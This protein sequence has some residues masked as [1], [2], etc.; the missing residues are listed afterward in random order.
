MIDSFE[1]RIRILKWIFLALF[2]VFGLRLFDLQVIQHKEYYAEAKAQHEK[3][4]VLPARRGKILVRKNQLTEEVTPVATNNTLKMLFVD[5]LVLSYPEYNPNL[6]LSEQEKN[7]PRVAAEILAPIL[8]NAHCEKVEGCEI[9]TNAAEWNDTEKTAIRSYTEELEKKITEI[10]RRRVLLV[11]DVSEERAQKINNLHLPGIWTEEGSVL[12]DP[13][14]VIDIEGTA[15]QLAPLLNIEER[16]IR[17]WINRRPK[18]YVEITRKI[19]P[20]VSQKIMALKEDPNYRKILR[21]VGLKDEYWRYY[22]EKNLAAQVMGFVDSAGVGQYGIEGQ[23]DHLLKGREGYIFGATNTRGQRI[24]SKSLGISHAQDGADVVLTID[25]VIQDAVEKILEEDLIKYDADFGQ[26]VVLEP[27]TGKVLAMVHYPTFDPNEF[28]KAFL[29]YE[30]TPEQA[31]IDREDED[32]NQRIPTIIEEGRYYRYFNT[33]GPAVFRNKIIADTYEPGSVMKAVTMASALNSDEV[34]PQTTYDDDGPVEVDEFKIRNADNIYAGPT[35]MVEVLNRSLNTGIAFITKK[36][37][38]QVL[39]DYFKGFGFGQYTDIELE[40]EEDGKIKPWR[41]WAE[42]ELITYGFGQGLTATPLQMAVAFSALAN[43][44][45]LTKPLLIEEIRYPDGTVEKFV[46][47]RIR[48]VI[49]DKTYQTIK[50]MLLNA[51]DNGVARGARVWGY[52]VM[53]KTGTSQTY[54]RGKALEGAGTTITSFAGFGPIREPKFVVLV[55]YDHPK[56]SQW[57]SE[58]AAITFRRVAKF[59]FSYMGV[60]PDR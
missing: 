26:I 7:D 36:V 55:K 44:G 43:G 58:T 16:L 15:E 42:S 57:G 30:I 3:K 18:R 34:T 38:R 50:S 53:G 52:S 47:E 12:A 24:L 10:E 32:F 56:F 31:E 33:W 59:L 46:P 19:V 2:I 4:S 41:E 17:K 37:G 13:T 45:Y 9:K 25:R 23:Y 28:G 22:P 21:G 48:R 49:S 27:Q 35:T 5:P 14:R 39:Y 11:N 1:S 40:G 6:P 8:I 51:V 29:R 60:P 54:H 20:E